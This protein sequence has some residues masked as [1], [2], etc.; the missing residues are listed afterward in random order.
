MNGVLGLA[1]L[2]LNTGLDEGQR[3]YVEMIHSS[4]EDLLVVINDILD[5]SKIE[6]GKLDLE[7][8]DFY[9]QSLL[10]DFVMNM[11]LRAQAK[12]LELRC[13]IAPDV[14]G[15]LCGDPG[16]LRQIL[17]NLM[18]NALKFT[19]EGEVAIPVSLVQAEGSTESG[20]G[21]GGV[22]LR[23][24]IRDTG[25]GIA[26]DKIG[27][28]FSKFT[29][30]DTSTTRQFGG[31]GLGLSIS[32]QLAELMGGQVGVESSLGQGS[33]F[34]FTVHMK[35]PTASSPAL[36]GELAERGPTQA[37]MTNRS[38]GH[39]GQ[40]VPS[41]ASSARILLVED[42]LTNQVIAQAM[43]KQLGLHADVA[44]NGQ[45]A[46]VTLEHK[47][48]DLVF[49]DVMMPGMDGLEATRRIRDLGSAVLDHGIP[50]IAMTANA[51]KGDR[52]RC[53]GAGMNDYVSKP[54]RPEALKAVVLRWLAK[55]EDGQEP[56]PAGDEGALGEEG[57]LGKESLPPDRARNESPAIFDRNDMAQRFQHDED[58]IRNLLSYFLEDILVQIKNLF[59]SMETGD[60]PAAELRAH[61]IKGAAANIGAQALRAVAEKLESCAKE[62]D[63]PAMQTHRE[64][65]EL[66]CERLREQLK[67]E[68]EGISPGYSPAKE[69]NT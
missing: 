54:I 28:L 69:R 9:L 24:A 42:N 64:E 65:L 23:F 43:L 19:H 48:Y 15:L 17:T 31:T 33:E 16:R 46:L 41:V 53:L 25:I 21:S 29:Q 39:S 52:D 14:P 35:I 22:D 10:N 50:I 57:A 36:S 60:L 38:T 49:M 61:T 66:Q 6:A 32:K 58:L 59:D 13:T 26:P 51:M 68:L 12:G 4:G 20:P 11:A 47:S 5:F 8:L 55:Q 7:S 18:G 30:A 40:Q 3:R 67:Q 2:L 37:L 62:G 27:Q 1:G 34:W 44:T 45:G 56:K 63:L